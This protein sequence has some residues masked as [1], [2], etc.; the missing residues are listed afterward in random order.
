MPH[1]N[2]G[3]AFLPQRQKGHIQDN[4]I[5]WSYADVMMGH[6]LR[7]WANIIP[8]KT[9]YRIYAKTIFLYQIRIYAKSTCVHALIAMEIFHYKSPTRLVSD[10]DAM[11]F[12]IL[13]LCDVCMRIAITFFCPGATWGVLLKMKSVS[14]GSFIRGKSVKGALFTNIIVNII[15]S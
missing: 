1:S 9:L 14:G 4:T 5:H 2:A 11:S 10:M 12:C 15:L 8:T 6:C 7:R 3:D 13:N